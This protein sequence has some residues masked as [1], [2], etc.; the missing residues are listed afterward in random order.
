M[1]LQVVCAVAQVRVIDPQPCSG[2]TAI[3]W[4]WLNAN[5]KN[6]RHYKELNMKGMEEWASGFPSLMGARGALGGAPCGSVL[7]DDASPS[8]DVDYPCE[9]LSLDQLMSL[10]PHLSSEGWYPSRHS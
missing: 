4:A 6:P 3:S 2:A 8:T 7:L 1:R 5:K 9:E 10:E